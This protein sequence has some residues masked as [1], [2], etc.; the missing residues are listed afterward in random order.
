MA[1]SE[2]TLAFNEIT[3]THHLPR[4]VVID[5]LRQALVSA[6]RR[7]MGVGSAQRIEADID[8]LTNRFRILVEKEVADSVADSR[9]E[10][11]LDEALKIDPNTQIGETLMVP[12]ETLNRPF[13][14]IAAQTAKQVILQKI[15]EA[16]VNRSTTSK[17]PRGRSRHGPGAKRQRP[18][19][20][21][22]PGA[23]RGDHAHQPANQRRALP[24]ARQ[25]PHLRPGS[26]RDQS[27]AAD[28]CLPRA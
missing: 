1:K 23:R 10:V 20:H 6:Y 18:E 9:T 12:E 21:A 26:Q 2:F 16:N 4:E 25:D 19:H 28:H 3:E 7:D 27:R 5:A 13:G 24:P 8:P 17:G 11:T 14:R 22:Q 15:R